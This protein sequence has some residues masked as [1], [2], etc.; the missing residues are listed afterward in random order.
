MILQFG[1]KKKKHSS[2]VFLFF[3]VSVWARFLVATNLFFCFARYQTA[4]SA[5]FLFGDYEVKVDFYF[6]FFEVFLLTF[7]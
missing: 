3:N 5:S 4:A 6:L 2:G 1:K 7:A